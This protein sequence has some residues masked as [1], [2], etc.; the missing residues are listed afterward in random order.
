MVR[1]GGLEPPRVA[2]LDPKSSASASSATLAWGASV[3]CERK[4]CKRLRATT[5]AALRAACGAAIGDRYHCGTSVAGGRSVGGKL[6]IEAR[7]RCVQI[8][9]AD[10]D[11]PIEDRTRLVPQE[12]HG[13]ALGHAAPDERARGDTWCHVANI[14]LITERCWSP[15]TFDSSRV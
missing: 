3:V 14:E 13:H 15:P 1:E 10:D 2:S 12:L 4:D 6:R 5:G 7:R 11:V 9:V 8:C